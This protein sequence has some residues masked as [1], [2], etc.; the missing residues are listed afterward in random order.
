MDLKDDIWGWI[1]RGRKDTTPH[2]KISSH[3][4]HA[5]IHDYA[6]RLGGALYLYIPEPPLERDSEVHNMFEV[7]RATG[8][9][10]ERPFLEDADHVHARIR[11]L[12]P[13]LFESEPPLFRIHRVNEDKLRDLV[14]SLDRR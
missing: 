14:A 4:V 12:K 11:T 3:D 1:V 8:T 13:R 6:A 9:V 5:V 2:R 7:L 10:A